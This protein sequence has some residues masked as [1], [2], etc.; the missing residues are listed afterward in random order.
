MAENNAEVPQA[1]AAK[2]VR[3]KGPGLKEKAGRIAAVAGRVGAAAGVAAVG[4][5][6]LDSAPHVSA[7][8]PTP[9]ART[10]TATPTPE[11][12]ISKA[13]KT[14]VNEYYKQTPTATPNADQILA[15]ARKR[16]ADEQKKIEAER[17]DAE[18]AA[19]RNTPTRTPTSSPTKEPSPTQPPSP[20]PDREATKE[21]QK[22]AEEERK[23]REDEA[24]GKE[25]ARLEAEYY[26]THPEAAPKTPTPTSIPEISEKPESRGG[27]GIPV[28]EIPWGTAARVAGAAGALVGGLLLFRRRIGG[29]T[30]ALVT[31]GI[32]LARGIWTGATGLVGRALAE[33]K[34]RLPHGRGPV[35]PPAPGGAPG[36]P[37]A[38]GAGP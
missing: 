38:G 27:G 28:G 11:D 24:Y 25:R 22:K 21:A 5:V 19:L 20:T 33:V 13:V 7:D 10:A 31:G 12:P 29:S 36:A 23:A 37:G 30:R 26:K 8:T 9:V 35:V 34:K 32:T 4:Y 6:A 2:V 15:E 16:F 1:E 18:T 17:I 3:K 14:A